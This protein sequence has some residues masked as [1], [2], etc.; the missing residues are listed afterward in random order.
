MLNGCKKSV[1]DNSPI[2]WSPIFS[3]KPV[4]LVYLNLRT[5]FQNTFPRILFINFRIVAATQLIMVKL[6]DIFLYEHR[7][8]WG[9]LH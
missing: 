6:R 3:Q 7:R 2:F 5:V 4:Y 9:L 1:I 8:I